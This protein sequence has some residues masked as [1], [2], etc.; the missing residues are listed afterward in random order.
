MTVCSPAIL[1][2]ADAS[3]LDATNPENAE[4]A[5]GE[6]LPMRCYSLMCEP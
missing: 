6:L 3:P 1:P 4:T 5:T 2:Q